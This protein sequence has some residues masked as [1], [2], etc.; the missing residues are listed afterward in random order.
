MIKNAFYRYLSYKEMKFNL[1]FKNG[2]SFTNDY[3]K[4]SDETIIDISE[5]Y[6]SKR[7]PQQD[8]YAT[9]TSIYCCTCFIFIE[10]IS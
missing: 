8:K 6:S 1:H 9:V 2:C 5:F 10:L 3:R 4:C 7:W